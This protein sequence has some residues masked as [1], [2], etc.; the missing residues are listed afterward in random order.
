MASIL[1]PFGCT[2]KAIEA[3]LL[4]GMGM[5][6]V[7]LNEN[8][9]CIVKTLFKV[10]FEPNV[11]YIIPNGVKWK[12]FLKIENSHISIW[13]GYNLSYTIFDPMPK[14]QFCFHK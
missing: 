11:N 6:A 13:T 4:E 2:R 3:N 7:R 5:K 9:L 8:D 12:F 14:C 10:Y 1:R